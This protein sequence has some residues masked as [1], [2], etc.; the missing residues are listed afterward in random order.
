VD[1]QVATSFDDRNDGGY[2][3]SSL[4]TSTKLGRL[5]LHLASYTPKSTSL[6]TVLNA[7]TIRA[8]GIIFASS[9]APEE[10]WAMTSSVLSSFI[11]REQGR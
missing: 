4:F 6:G 11:G 5:A 7:E 2:S 9:S 3:W 8:S 10:V 1:P